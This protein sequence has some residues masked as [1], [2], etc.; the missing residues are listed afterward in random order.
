MTSSSRRTT[1]AI[2]SKIARRI[3]AHAVEIRELAR[4][5]LA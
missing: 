3:G 1:A 2:A 5:R 4:D